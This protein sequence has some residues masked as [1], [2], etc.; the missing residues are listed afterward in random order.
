[1]VLVA[2]CKRFISGTGDY[3]LHPY[4]RL[5]TGVG[6]NTVDFIPGTE[7]LVPASEIDDQG[8]WKP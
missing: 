3:F 4:K 6:S 8:R 2:S 7:Q 1:M 5:M